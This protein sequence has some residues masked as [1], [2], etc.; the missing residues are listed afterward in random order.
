MNGKE[1]LLSPVEYIDYWKATRFC[2]VL[3]L[4]SIMIIN[5]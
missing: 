1:R 2:P 4:F 3:R 5:P